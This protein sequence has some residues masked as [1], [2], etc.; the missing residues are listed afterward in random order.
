MP[1]YNC[2][3]CRQKHSHNDACGR[4]ERVKQTRRD[5]RRPIAE[6]LSMDS[7]PFW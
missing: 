7:T 2:P 1:T 4:G 3:N 5:M 6:F